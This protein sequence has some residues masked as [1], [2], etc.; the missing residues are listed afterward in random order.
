[1]KAFIHHAELSASKAVADIEAHFALIG[2]A[3]YLKVLELVAAEAGGDDTRR[4]VTLSW[5]AWAASLAGEQ[6]VLAEFFAFCHDHGAL[7]VEDDGERVTVECD[8][9][10]LCRGMRAVPEPAGDQTLF[11]HHDQWVAWFI[12][13]LSYSPKLAN[14]PDNLRMFRRWCASNVTVGEMTA[15]V[16]R[17]IEAGTGL[18]TPALHGHLQA[19]RAQRIKEAN[20]W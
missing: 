18:G 1:M 9:L 5:D 16:Q 19:L 4:K 10:D 11:T 2:Y 3:R 20:E 7:S 12:D 17:T 13:D 6:E 15:A 8:G 14:Q